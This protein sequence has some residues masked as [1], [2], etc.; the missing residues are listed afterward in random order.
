MK[1]SSGHDSIKAF[2]E[3]CP[4]SL[5]DALEATSHLEHVA[6]CDACA[7]LL[8]EHP[9]HAEALVAATR[10]T[11]E[12][13]PSEVIDHVRAEQLEVLVLG[14]ALCKHVGEATARLLRDPLTSEQKATLWEVGESA[15]PDEMRAALAIVELCVGLRSLLAVSRDGGAVHLTKE[16]VVIEGG[17]EKRV[18][19]DYFI[20]CM[21]TRMDVQHNLAEALFRATVEVLV[22]SG[23]GMPGLHQR[24]SRGELPVELTLVGAAAE[25]SALPGSGGGK[26]RLDTGT[27]RPTRVT[28]STRM[29]RLAAF[30]V[31]HED[32]T[33]GE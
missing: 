1:D 20:A 21:A 16:G 22:D 13:T 14:R 6:S 19:A 31:R 11:D 29:Q 26:S 9:A 7:K 2:L 4:D 23:T 3:T 27:R 18:P 32:S 5:P 33:L 17:T 30:V 15:R 25:E 8:F 12:A 10:P 24:S 28:D